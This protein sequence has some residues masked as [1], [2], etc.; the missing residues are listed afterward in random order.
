MRSCRLWYR[1]RGDR[2]A[3]GGPLTRVQ[4][5]GKV[6]PLQRKFFALGERHLAARNNDV[7][8]LVTALFV[9]HEEVKPTD[10]RAEREL[11]AAGGGR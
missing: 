10:N 9:H 11:R 8:N 7:R 5:I 4:L 3:C 1:F 2:A 6:T